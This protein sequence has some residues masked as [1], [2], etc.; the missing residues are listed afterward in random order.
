MEQHPKFVRTRGLPGTTGPLL[1]IAL[2]LLAAGSIL[3][4]VEDLLAEYPSGTGVWCIILTLASCALLF[5]GRRSPAASICAGA[6]LFFG[7]GYA[8]SSPLPFAMLAWLISAIGVPFN[9]APAMLPKPIRLPVWNLVSAVLDILFLPGALRMLIQSF[10]A[11]GSLTV[12]ALALLAMALGVLLLDLSV[13]VSVVSP[14]GDRPPR[15]RVQ[16]IPQPVVILRVGTVCLMAHAIRTLYSYLRMMVSFDI[17]LTDLLWPLLVLAAGVLL[18]LKDQWVLH[19]RLSLILL[20]VVKLR[21]V[22]AMREMQMY[23]ED[24]P[25]DPSGVLFVALLLML[26][27]LLG[28]RWNTPVR[29]KARTIP[30]L[31]LIAA[32]LALAG[33]IQ[34]IQG[35]LDS[36]SM[37]S[38]GASGAVISSFLRQAVWGLLFPLGLVLLD[39]SVRP[40]EVPN[41]ARTARPQYQKGLGGLIQ[42]FYGNVGGH[43]QM[44]AK[45]Q[46]I[47]C[48][49]CGLLSLVVAL[50]GALL[51]LL[52][53]VGLVPIVVDGLSIVLAGLLSAVACV[54][55]AVFTWP[56]YAFGQITADVHTIKEGGQRP[57]TGERPLSLQKAPQPA[58]RPDD[59]DELPEL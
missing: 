38:E 21:D 54:L 51:F 57:E 16:S 55:L 56:L 43:L 7:T 17:P 2:V 24:P 19:C 48:L 58:A 9:P 25:A 6:L 1:P 29:V 53:L 33:C 20:L 42:R 3:V 45:I 37:M 44:L 18:F 59:P 14:V 35:A 23:L 26:I 5:F 27:G 15:M 41:S 28:V 10:D 52:Q 11:A 12:Q 32:L 30:L 46:G 8:G 4:V 39:L 22:L 49:V 34:V 50:L 47:I 13:Q 40:V 31:S 36:V